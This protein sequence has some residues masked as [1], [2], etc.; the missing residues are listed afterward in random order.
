MDNEQTD[1]FC[2]ILATSRQQHNPHGGI[3]T[4]CIR[5]ILMDPNPVLEILKESMMNF[6][7]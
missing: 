6:L 5:P 2:P 4:C 1:T 7:H 3:T